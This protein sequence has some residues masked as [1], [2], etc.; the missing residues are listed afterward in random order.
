MRVAVEVGGWEH[1]CCG[2]AYERDALVE[3]TCLAVVGPAG[4]PRYAE[5]HHDRGARD[6]V[7]VRGRIADL[8]ILHGDGTSDPI[9]RLPGG[10]ALRGHD[11]E[12][13]GHLESASNGQ[14]VVNDS[15]RFLLTVAT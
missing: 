2:P 13:D 15:G 11:D 5:T 14:P 10:S 4:V 3:L 9:S 6:T 12:D 1:E 7:T 8:E